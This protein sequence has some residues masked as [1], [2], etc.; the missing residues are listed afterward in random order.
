MVGYDFFARLDMRQI[1][2]KVGY[3]TTLY[4]TGYETIF[5]KVVYEAT[6]KH[7]SVHA[8]CHVNISASN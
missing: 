2:C 6:I 5:C 4:K 3:E 7:I 8:H 1:L